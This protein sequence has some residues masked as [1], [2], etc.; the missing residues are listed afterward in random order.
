MSVKNYEDLPEQVADALLARLADDD[1]F[2]ALFSAD[3][4]AALAELG[5]APALSNAD[6]GIWESLTVN[7]LADKATFQ[8]SLAQLR[9]DVLAARVVADPITLDQSR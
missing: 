6:T 1:D 3:P 2:R 8:T 4:R 9:S 5:Y 7:Q